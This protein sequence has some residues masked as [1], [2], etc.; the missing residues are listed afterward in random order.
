MFNNLRTWLLLLA[1][2]MS[3]AVAACGGGDGATTPI[4]NPDPGSG[5]TGGDNP[6]ITPYGMSATAFTLPNGYTDLRGVASSMQYVYVADANT[7][8]AFDKFGNYINQ[9]TAPARIQAIAV[10]PTTPDVENVDMSAYEFAGFPVILHDPVEGVGYIRIYGPNLDTLTTIEDTT[11]PD[12]PKYLALPAGQVDPPVGDS[13]LEVVGVYDMTVDRFGSILA[14]VDLNYK[15]S[16]PNPDWIRGLQIFNQFHGYAIETP[17]SYSND[18]DGPDGP[19]PPVTFAIPLFPQE[20]GY[21]IGDMGTCGIDTF[22]PFNRTDLQ[23]TYYTGDYNLLRDYVGVAY[24]TFSPYTELYDLSRSATNSFGFNRVIGESVG[25]AP[26]SFNQN[27]AYNPDGGLE[28]TDLSN[29]GPSGIFCDPMTDNVLICDPGNRRIQVFNPTTGAFIRQ[30][31]NGTR[32]RAGNAF[33]APSSIMMDYE[34]NMFV[35]DVNDLRLLRE[36]QPGLHFGSVG[37]T[38][39]RLDNLQPLQGATVS[40]GNEAGNLGAVATNINGD[41]IIRYLL[42]GTYYMTSTKFAYDSDTATVQILSDTTIR[43]DFNLRPR[44]PA[45]TGSYVGSIIDSVTN[46]PLTDVTVT[47]VGTSLVS[48]TDSLGRF[49]FTTMAPGVYQVVY[50]KTGYQTLTRDIEI[51]GGST[52][53][54]QLLQLVPL[55]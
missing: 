11:K 3:L 28:D 44:T 26:G 53:A 27:P 51:I 29:G 39:R 45:T 32:G 5:D 6:D 24:I 25:S 15:P 40:I 50:T 46:L 14:V 35:S 48:T 7:V 4:D 30:I 20:D 23:Y 52:T 36:K 31:G 22:F 42:I 21:A 41:Y 49:L 9:V 18:P 54:D 12:A 17:G 55:S 19:L 47:V 37:G 1:V 8:Y 33:L 13:D 34:G 38:V 43:A 10:F 2:V 16:T